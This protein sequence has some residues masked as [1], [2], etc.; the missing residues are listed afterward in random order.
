LLSIRFIGTDYWSAEDTDSNQKTKDYEKEKL[1]VFQ[2]VFKPQFNL[3]PIYFA[4]SQIHLPEEALSHHSSY[5]VVRHQT[6]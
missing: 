6:Q 1:G 2:G 3:I 4:S 5:N